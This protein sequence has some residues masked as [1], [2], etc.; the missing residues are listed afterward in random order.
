M[1]FT[2][3]PQPDKPT[4]PAIE[5]AASN[6]MVRYRLIRCPERRSRLA[7][8]TGSSIRAST[9]EPIPRTDE[10]WP[11]IEMV[12]GSVCTLTVTVCAPP[13]DGMLA[14]EKVAVASDGRPL[15]AK[16]T[17]AG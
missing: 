15:A 11:F 1:S 2:P 16:F 12:G 10:G 5:A 3:E 4:A 9:S 6:S 8:A 13:L 17:V 14:G 7:P